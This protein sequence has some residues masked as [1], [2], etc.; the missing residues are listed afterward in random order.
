MTDIAVEQL[1]SK[2]KELGRALHLSEEALQV[3]ETKYTDD[4]QRCLKVI[5]KWV[6]NSNGSYSVQVLFTVIT[7]MAA[8][9]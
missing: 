5:L 4:N 8:R 2:W 6:L 7:N 1:H 3:I 9:V